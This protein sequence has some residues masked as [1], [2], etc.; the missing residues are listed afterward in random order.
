MLFSAIGVVRA[1]QNCSLKRASKRKAWGSLERKEKNAPRKQEGNIGKRKKKKN[2]AFGEPCLC[3]RDT[4][5]FRHFRRFHGVWAGK[6]LFHWLE[7]KFV[8]FAVF[9][10]PPPRF[11]RGQRHGLPKALVFGSREKTWW[12]FR[13]RKNIFP[14]PPPKGEPPPRASWDFQQK[15][16][17]SPPPGRPGLPLSL[18]P[19]RE[20][21]KN[22]RNVRNGRFGRIDSREPFA[23]QKFLFL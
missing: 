23:I 8:I 6:T 7:H 18:P 22:I 16:P 19:S 14:P 12:A 11:S 10:K 20:E 15:K 1:C 17:T 2:H 21:I 4:R 9:V 3:P 5:H 13:P